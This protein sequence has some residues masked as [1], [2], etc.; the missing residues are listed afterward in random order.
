VIDGRYRLVRR[1]GAGGMG[2]VYEGWHEVTG[3]QVAVKLLQP[4]T[5]Q[6]PEI[7]ARFAREACTGAAIGHPSIVA[8]LEAGNLVDRTPFLVMELLEGE[9]LQRTLAR[10]TRLTPERTVEIICQAASA[11]DALH[12]FGIVHRDVKTDNLFIV[13]GGGVK[14]LDFGL[15]LFTQHP[16]SARLTGEG[17]VNGTPHYLPPEVF[18]AEPPT[19]AWD[20]YALATVAFELLTGVLPFE[21]SSPMVTLF[22]KREYAAPRLGDSV[23]VQ[24]SEAIERVIRRGLERDPAQ[25]HATPGELAADLS[26]AVLPLERPAIAALPAVLASDSSRAWTFS[27]PRVSARMLPGA[28]IAAVCAAATCIAWMA[29][30]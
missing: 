16:V 7:L 26:R 14:L 19:P 25:R 29:G 4:A 3:K 15:A 6:S 18:D 12:S 27:A 28:V 1:I 8:V 30:G 24:F 10:D 23:D 20:V 22:Q 17:V 11:L 9:S 5:T 13:E 2:V 21:G